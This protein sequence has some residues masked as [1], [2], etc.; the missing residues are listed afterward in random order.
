MGASFFGDVAPDNFATF[1]AAFVTLFYVT[2]GDP[3]PDSLPKYNED[4]TTNW[5]VLCE[6]YSLNSL[7]SI[8]HCH[9]SPPAKSLFSHFSILTHQ[10]STPSLASISPSVFSLPL[11]FPCTLVSLPDRFSSRTPRNPALFYMFYLSSSPFSLP[12]SPFLPGS[13]LTFTRLHPALLKTV[14]LLRLMDLCETWRML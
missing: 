9:S 8:R 10:Q 13:T 3:W 5:E 14:G 11:L 7:A 2:G 1:D 12:I 6:L 4:G